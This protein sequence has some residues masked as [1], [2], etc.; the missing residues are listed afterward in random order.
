MSFKNWSNT[1]ADIQFMQATISKEEIS[2]LF[3]F[4]P[5]G[6]Y[7]FIEIVYMFKLV[8]TLFSNSRFL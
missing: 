6:L 8:L 2:N 7:N 1:I 5:Y 4:N 3:Y